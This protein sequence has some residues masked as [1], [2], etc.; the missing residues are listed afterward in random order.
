MT[1]LLDSEEAEEESTG[2]G[3]Y[4]EVQSTKAGEVNKAKLQSLLGGV[5]I[6]SCLFI[7]KKDTK[8]DFLK[9]SLLHGPNWSE[10]LWIYSN[11]DYFL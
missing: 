1:K 2:E 8:L 5:V 3:D 6:Y 4:F 11:F 10:K 7:G 9:T